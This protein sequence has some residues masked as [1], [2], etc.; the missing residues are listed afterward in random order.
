MESIKKYRPNV[1]IMKQRNTEF[2]LL[3]FTQALSKFV[4]VKT[5]WAMLSV[6][7]LSGWKISDWWRRSIETGPGHKT[8]QT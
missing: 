7:S 5:R 3:N 6:N 4:G 8:G 2:S 1:Q